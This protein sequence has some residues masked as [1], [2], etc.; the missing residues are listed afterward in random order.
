[1]LASGWWVLAWN[2][3]LLL[4]LLLL[5]HLPC[6]CLPSL[7]HLPASSFH[8]PLSAPPCPYLPCSYSCA[9]AG[10]VKKEFFQLLVTELLCP[11]YGMLIYQ[12]ESR[13]YWFN[14]TTLEADAEFLLLGLVLG[15]AIYNGVLLD[16]PL[17]LALYRKILGQEVK[18]RDLED[19][20]PMLGRW[21]WAGVTVWGTLLPGVS[22]AVSRHAGPVCCLWHVV[23]RG[24]AAGAPASASL[25]TWPGTLFPLTP[26]FASSLTE[27][28]LLPFPCPCRC[29]PV[30]QEPAPAAAVRGPRQ[31]GAHLLPVVCGG[32]ARLWGL[33]GG[34]AQGGRRRHTGHGCV[35]R[36]LGVTWG[37]RGCG[38]GIIGAA[39]GVSV[40][41]GA[42]RAQLP[43]CRPFLGAGCLG[44]GPPLLGPPSLHLSPSFVPP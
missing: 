26:C 10:G 24:L 1:M 20:Q 8:L 44:P 5:E 14:P 21:V 17:P 31:R 18:L 29:F 25:R 43:A 40:T 6:R 38:G 9:A 39:R 7:L 13:T 35:V 27:S 22:P 28:V 37:Q 30:L 36:Q 34:A 12:P 2:E 32:G 16:F 4:L 3:L 33:K 41:L 42:V 11:D 23:M 15:L 19:M